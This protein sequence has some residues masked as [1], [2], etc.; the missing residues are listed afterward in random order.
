MNL[1]VVKK[2][3]RG[4]TPNT[5]VQPFSAMS[6]R[7]AFAQKHLNPGIGRIFDVVWKSASGSWVTLDDDRRILDF[8][9]GIGVTNLGHVH[10][11]VTKAVQDQ[12]AN[13]VHAQYSLG[14]HK[15][16]LDL[17]EKMLPIVPKDLT[18]VRPPMYLYV[19]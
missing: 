19:M 18:S 14:F 10:P 4:C 16:M 8:A 12:A 17:I 15:P 2:F 5:F 13:V 3:V 11:K 7:L 1:N 9:S 6:S